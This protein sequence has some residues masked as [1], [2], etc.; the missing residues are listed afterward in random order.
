MGTRTRAF[1]RLWLVRLWVQRFGFFLLV[2]AGFALLIIGRVDSPWAGRLRAGMLD[3]VAPV[4][5]ALALPGRA[6][7]EWF[8][9]V[10]SSTDLQ[11]QNAELKGEIESLRLRLTAMDELARENQ[12]FSKLLGVQMPDEGKH[13]AARVISEPGGPYV[14]SVLISAGNR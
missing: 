9:S 2:A 6:V 8:G 13:I 12:E 1:G 14:R 10:K 7:S 11:R 4:A 3:A 5:H